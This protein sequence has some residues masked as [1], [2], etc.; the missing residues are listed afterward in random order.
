[1]KNFNY[2]YVHDFDNLHEQNDKTETFRKQK[3]NAKN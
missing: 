3:E 1:M 2:L